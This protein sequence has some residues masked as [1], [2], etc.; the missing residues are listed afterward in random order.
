[1]SDFIIACPSSVCASLWFIRKH[2]N[3]Y[4]TNHQYHFKR[5]MSLQ[6]PS[7]SQRDAHNPTHLPRRT[8]CECCVQLNG[9]DNHHKMVQAQDT[10]VQVDLALLKDEEGGESTCLL[11][12]RH[13]SDRY[14]GQVICFRS[15][16]NDFL[17]CGKAAANTS[18]DRAVWRNLEDWNSDFH[19]RV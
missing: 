14:I 11:H 10:V 18:I 6:E 3:R 12:L 1:M 4:Q 19:V 9:E 2:T 17:Q 15:R 8:W 5:M 13:F 16:T 7:E